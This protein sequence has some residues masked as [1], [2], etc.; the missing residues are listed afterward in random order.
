MDMSVAALPAIS[1]RANEADKKH[2]RYNEWQRYESSCRRNMIN[3]TNFKNWLSSLE[4]GENRDTWAK[5]PEYKNFM[6]W[7]RETQAGAR[8]CQPTQDRPNGF[9]FPENF[10]FWIAGSR[11]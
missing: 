10:K 9:V 1:G 5:H 2:P 3:G 7:M 6:A 8:K 4:A 11:W